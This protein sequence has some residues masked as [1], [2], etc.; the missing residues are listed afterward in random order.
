[1]GEFLGAAAGLLMLALVG[2][3]FIRFLVR[4]GALKPGAARRLGR[5]AL[6]LGVA[7]GMHLGIAAL[8]RSVIYGLTDIT[9]LDAVFP[10]A[11][12]QKV[13][14]GLRSPSW[15]GPL[16]G[17]TA[18]LGHAM[19]KLLFGRYVLGGLL[20]SF[21]ID[22]AACVLILARGE[23]LLDAGRAERGLFLL[24]CMPGAIFCLLPGWA[25]LALLG[26][27]LLFYFL[28]KRLPARA[29]KMPDALYGALL[30]L[31]GM[32]SALLAFGLI[33]GQAG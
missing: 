3:L 13:L 32:L 1:M 4:A 15:E 6:L 14:A 26:G 20:V 12:V 2:L 7:A 30:A 5:A 19:G 11:S 8:L 17:L 25:C 10:A 16:S 28:G 23:R 22:W 24:L 9:R 33:S 27:A 29:W 18:H 21:G 31:A